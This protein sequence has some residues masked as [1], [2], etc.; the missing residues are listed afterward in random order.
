[1]EP[2]FLRV[3]M[4]VRR[5]QLGLRQSWLDLSAERRLEGDWEANRLASS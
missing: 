1:M 2:T 4:R 3:R 5:R